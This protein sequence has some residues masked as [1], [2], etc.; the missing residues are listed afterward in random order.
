MAEQ[1]KRAQQEC[2]LCGQEVEYDQDLDRDD[3]A[4]NVL[5][6]S[7]CNELVCADCMGFQ[8]ILRG[9]VRRDF[10]CRICIRPSESNVRKEVDAPETVS[11]ETL[12]CI[13]QIAL[14]GLSSGCHRRKQ[15]CLENVVKKVLGQDGFLQICLNSKI[16]GYKWNGFV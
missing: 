10:W 14:E 3:A 12:R 1:G 2:M 15:D 16:D 9:H 7:R 6:C 13:V 5:E 4:C 11:H 8:G